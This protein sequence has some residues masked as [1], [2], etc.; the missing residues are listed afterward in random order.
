[1]KS[2]KSQIN[3][4]VYSSGKISHN[5]KRIS[6][7]LAERVTLMEKVHIASMNVNNLPHISVAE[8][9]IVKRLLTKVDSKRDSDYLQELQD[10]HSLVDS[11]LKWTSKEHIVFT[12]MVISLFTLNLMYYS[13]HT[14]V[15]SFLFCA[16]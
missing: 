9:A 5:L 14:Y 15:Y 1:M 4:L 16:H 6:E 3:N 2:L 8:L 13:S 10:L 11:Y 7:L 12:W